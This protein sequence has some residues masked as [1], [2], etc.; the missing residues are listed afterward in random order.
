MTRTNQK[1]DLGRFSEPD[2]AGDRGLV[3]RGLWFLIN[4]VVLQGRLPLLPSGAKAA[5][6]RLFGARVGPGA[7]IKPRVTIK[8]PWFLELG[9]NAWIGEGVWID[10][11]GMVTVG[12]NVCISQDAYLVTG[13]HDFTRDDF[14][15]F[16]QPIT[17][18]EKA[19]ICAK[20]IV[21][22]GSVIPA[23]TVVPIGSVWRNPT[24]PS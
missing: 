5:L 12:A 1:L 8:Y 7:V 20:A 22:P 4:A 11:P 6:L 10:N 23:N 16:S 21:P 14:R 19:W 18:G 2:I 9:A 17:V 13:N 15:F 24:E 3:V